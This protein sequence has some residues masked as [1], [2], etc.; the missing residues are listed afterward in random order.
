MLGGSFTVERQHGSRVSLRIGPDSRISGVRGVGVYNEQRTGFNDT[1]R[2]WHE[3]TRHHA[4]QALISIAG[5]LS[6]VQNTHRSV[7]RR[8]VIDLAS[9]RVRWQL[10]RRM[11]RLFYE[12]DSVKAAA[13]NVQTPHDALSLGRRCLE[14]VQTVESIA[15]AVLSSEVSNGA[16]VVHSLRLAEESLREASH[17]PD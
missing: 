15:A 16:E 14:L 8:Y 12:V 13:A 3:Q 4:D 11:Q 7:I 2:V 5:A 17:T 1:Y 10:A 6:R 9:V